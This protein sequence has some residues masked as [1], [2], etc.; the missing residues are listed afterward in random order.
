[1]TDKRIKRPKDPAQ[2]AKL[3][4]DIATG[5]VEDKAPYDEKDPAAQSLG[6]KGGAAR[7]KSLTSE[8]RKEIAQKAAKSRWKKGQE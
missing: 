4:M 1:M 2:L 6:K 8:Q 7:A 5:E 3:I